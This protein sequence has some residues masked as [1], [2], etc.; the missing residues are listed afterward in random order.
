MF[1]NM[2]NDFRQDLWVSFQKS[3]NDG[4][5]A[6]RHW[7]KRRVIVRQQIRYSRVRPSL[8]GYVLSTWWVA[9]LPGNLPG[10]LPAAH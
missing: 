3:T 1:A 10:V 7:E 8:G 9:P 4:G 2:K 6:V 5:L